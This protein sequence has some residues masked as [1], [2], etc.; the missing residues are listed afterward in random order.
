MNK[1][2]NSSILTAA[3]LI[4]VA[5]VT[6]YFPHPPNFTAIGAMAIFGGAA[7]SNKKLA[8]LLPLTALF[9]SDV[10]LQLFSSTKGFYGTSQY[11]VYGA[12]MIITA[13]STLMK[14]KSAT[15]IFFAAIWSGVIFFIISNFGTWVS[16]DLYP[17]TL[18]GL[19]TCFIEAI[20]F[21][22]NEFFGNFLLNT[23]FGNLFFSAIL[24]GIYAIT[25][26]TFS[27]Q[28]AIA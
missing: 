7:I 22:K 27:T 3:F 28:K 17:K 8:F 2:N 5:A 9:L 18:N 4:L 24:F 26:K 10:A 21:Y 15:N 16:G 19:S 25:E 1:Q 20:P 14:K 23:V 6:R 12:F 11:F 13:L